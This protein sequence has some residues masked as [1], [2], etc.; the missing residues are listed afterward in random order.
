MKEIQ[1][2]RRTLGARWIADSVSLANRGRVSDALAAADRAASIDP[3]LPQPHAIAAK[4]Q[5]WEGNL[6]GAQRQL[7]EA[8]SRGLDASDCSAMQDAIDEMRER[9]RIAA[10]ARARSAELRMARSVAMLKAVDAFGVWCTTQRLAMVVML[11]AMVV[12][13]MLAVTY[14][15]VVR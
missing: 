5:F 15:G 1:T 12:T 4:L 13:L 2:L 7:E 8:K 11:L 6:D 14:P 10:R 9:S 3:S